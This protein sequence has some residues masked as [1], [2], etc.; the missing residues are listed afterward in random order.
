LWL[1][2]AF[3]LALVGWYEWAAQNV[4]TAGPSIIIAASSSFSLATRACTVPTA[5]P[6]IIIAAPAADGNH[7]VAIFA[8]GCFWCVE[9]DFDK[10]PGVISTTSGYTG[11]KI[12][13]PSYE[14]V[15]SHTTGH[16]EAVKIVF[17]PAKVSYRQLVDHFW[18]T[19]DPTVR[20]RQFCDI[21][22]PYRTVIFAT[23]DKQLAQAQASKAALETNKPFT[24]PIVTDIRLADDFYAAEGYHQDYYQ[25]NPVRYEY[26]RTSCGRDARLRQLWGDLAGK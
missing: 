13:N 10:V 1:A 7:Q 4:P 18:H 9:S 20:D 26:Y 15:S 14:E 21:G 22:T 19:I 6:S 8:G 23:S 25:K 16:A 2:L 12:A 5:G 24:E 11:G 17:D 3:I